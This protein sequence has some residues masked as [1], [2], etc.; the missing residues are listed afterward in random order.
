[1]FLYQK[2][3]E[4]AFNMRLHST[5]MY[6]LFS[7]SIGIINMKDEVLQLGAGFIVI[8]RT[9]AVAGWLTQYYLTFLLCQR[10]ALYTLF[11]HKYNQPPYRLLPVC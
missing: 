8:L 6:L 11:S 9:T 3:K 1:M 2:D 5:V 4:N 10:Q 7:Y